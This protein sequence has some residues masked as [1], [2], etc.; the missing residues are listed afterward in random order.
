MADILS[1]FIGPLLGGG[2]GAGLV[3]FGLNYWQAERNFYRSKLESLYLA[4][5][6]YTLVMFMVS[7]EIQAGVPLTPDKYKAQEDSDVISL[8]VNLYFPRLLPVFEKFKATM[9]DSIVEGGKFK[10]G[11]PNFKQ[12][13]LRLAAEGETLKSAIIDLAREQQ[14]FLEH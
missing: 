3:T 4:V 6:R 9:Q 12:D 13:L 10:M 7:S 5:H 11:N 8:L 1:N 2:L 14:I